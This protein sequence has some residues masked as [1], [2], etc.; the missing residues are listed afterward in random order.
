MDCIFCKIAR[1]EIPKKFDY[2]DE[3]I[4]AFAD[5]NPV[6]PV[7]ILLVPKKHYED[8]YNLDDQNVLFSM[9]KGVRKIVDDK[10]L[11]GQGFRIITNGGGAQ[12]VN[13][14]HFHLMGPVD[15]Q[16]KI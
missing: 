15:S 12:L 5:I 3:Y 11:I 7:H 13:H 4:M 10:K 9:H 14:L 2:E 6:R 1:K 16:E 8:L